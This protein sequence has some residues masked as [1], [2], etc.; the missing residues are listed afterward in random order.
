[1]IIRNLYSAVNMIRVTTSRT[2]RWT[3]H[4]ARMG[5]MRSEEVVMTLT[6][7]QGVV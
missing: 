3:R 6:W 4:V 1:L 5:K 2:V 7:R